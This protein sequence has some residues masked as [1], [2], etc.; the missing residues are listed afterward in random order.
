[1]AYLIA[2]DHN[3]EFDK[4]GPHPLA[5]KLLWGSDFPMPIRE[6]EFNDYKKI[7]SEFSR[8]IDIKNIKNRFLET[9][10]EK[11]GANKLPDR[12]SLLESLTHKNP[13]RFLF[14]D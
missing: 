3:E 4:L 5:D 11:F 13:M 14:G 7:M 6:R 8:T 1:M 9:P 12:N 10:K 2:L